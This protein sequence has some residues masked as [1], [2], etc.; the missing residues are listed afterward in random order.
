MKQKKIALAIVD[1]HQIVIDGLK[2]LLQG[3]EQFVVVHE[4]THP[5]DM[6]RL[7]EIKPAE[8]LLTDVMM[9]VMN[10]NEFCH[11]LKTDLDTSH[12]PV[13]M[14]TALTSVESQMEGFETGADDY[15]VKP[16]DDRILILRIRNLL[17]SRRILRDKFAR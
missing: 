8:I 6:C 5:E 10:G 3:H 17:E 7:L 13:L 14:M 9:P 12:I 16:F 15:M 4:T 2:S 1:D 11:L